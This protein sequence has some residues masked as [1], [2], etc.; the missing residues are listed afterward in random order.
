MNRYQLFAGTTLLALLAGGAHAQTPKETIVMAKQI[1]DI[2]S[3]DP[4]EAFEFSESK[5][6]PTSTTS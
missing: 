3:L 6:A 1:D 4:A 5:S 2:I